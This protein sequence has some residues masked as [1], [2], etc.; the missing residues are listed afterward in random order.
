[1]YKEIAARAEAKNLSFSKAALQLI[2]IGI[3]RKNEV[4]KK[5]MEAL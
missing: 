1:M 2:E 5:L 4:I 3:A